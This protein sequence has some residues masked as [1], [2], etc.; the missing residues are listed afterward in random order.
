MTFTDDDLKRLKGYRPNDGE[1][2]LWINFEDFEALLARL[3]AAEKA[4]KH[5]KA[6]PYDYKGNRERFEAWRKTAGK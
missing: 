5:R 6:W 2:G 4:L 3:G 1:E